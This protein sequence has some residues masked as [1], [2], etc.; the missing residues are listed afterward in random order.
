MLGA[1][2]LQSACDKYV[3]DFVI[4]IIDLIYTSEVGT[5]N[6]GLTKLLEARFTTGVPASDF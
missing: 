6:I 3:K 5:V 1:E 4:I 2:A